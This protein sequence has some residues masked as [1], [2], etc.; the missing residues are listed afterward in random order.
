M[1]FDVALMTSSLV[2]PN[3]TM[4]HAY[5]NITCSLRISILQSLHVSLIVFFRAKLISVGERGSP[6]Y[7]LD[8]SSKWSDNMHCSLAKNALCIIFFCNIFLLNKH[9]FRV[10]LS[11]SVLFINFLCLHYHMLVRN[12]QKLDVG[13]FRICDF[14]PKFHLVGNLELNLA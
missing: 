11:L 5:T 2:S 10:F 1:S 8:L 14:F 12:L 4:S 6:C 7:R 9:I 3:T 13:L